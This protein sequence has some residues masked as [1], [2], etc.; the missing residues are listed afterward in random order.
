MNTLENSVKEKRSRP[1][2]KHDMSEL[3]LLHAAYCPSYFKSRYSCCLL[4]KIQNLKRVRI[5]ASIRTFALRH[6]YRF[7]VY[8]PRIFLLQWE[9]DA[10]GNN[11]RM[12]DV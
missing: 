3:C 9:S 2:R 5:S 7:F 1:V 4:K 8:S 11:E 6:K 10:V 12:K